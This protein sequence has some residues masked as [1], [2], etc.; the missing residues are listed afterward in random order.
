MS[1]QIKNQ[2]EEEVMDTVVTETYD[3]SAIHSQDLV[4]A[5]F[6]KGSQTNEAAIKA[7]ELDEY[8]T[9][10]QTAAGITND[11]DARYEAFAKAEAYLID[12]ALVIP[13][14]PYSTASYVATKLNVFEGQYAAFGKMTDGFETLDEIAT[15]KTGYADRPMFDMVI[16][17]IKVK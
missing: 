6:F 11:N 10:F 15:T 13:Y 4:S 5:L 16:K 7:L 12:H 9:L 1:E 14:G 2:I 3:A 17:T 8:E